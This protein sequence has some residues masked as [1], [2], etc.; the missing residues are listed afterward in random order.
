MA[1]CA[2]LD[3]VAGNT[4]IL[5]IIVSPD[6]HSALTKQI[7]DFWA[8]EMDSIIEDKFSLPKTRGWHGER[9][10]NATGREQLRWRWWVVDEFVDDC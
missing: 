4:S 3:K 10:S 7:W 5:G 8:D 2:I 9:E 1:S 6:T